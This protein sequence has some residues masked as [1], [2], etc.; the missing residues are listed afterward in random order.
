MIEAWAHIEGSKGYEVSTIGR[1][2]SVRSIY[3][4]SVLVERVLSPGLTNGYPA[5]SVSFADGRKI[6]KRIHRLVAQAFIR[7]VDNKPQVAHKNGNR[8]D[9]RVEN[10]Y[11]ATQFEN[12][13]DK[14]AH[15]KV[16]NGEKCKN[17]VLTESMV[18]EAR[19]RG[20]SGES[21]ASIARSMGVS[22][23]SVYNAIIGATWSHVQV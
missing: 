12:E 11:W 5:V 13:A 1:V 7:N 23:S 2:R 6:V 22:Q 17:A 16:V 14:V 3:K 4:G 15:G 20:G 18:R 21:A 8:E 10:L 19:I 9:N